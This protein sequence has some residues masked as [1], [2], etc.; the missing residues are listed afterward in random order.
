MAG[1]FTIV[2]LGE[3]L[4]DIFADQQIL[5][6]AP[7]NMAAAAHQLSKP[8]GG[9]ALVVSRVG[10]D[11]LGRQIIDQL[12][13]RQMEVGYVGTDPDRS[14]GKVFVTMDARGEPDFQIVENVA[15]DRIQFDS[16]DEALAAS[17]DGVCFG[18]LAQR[19]GESRSSI[20]HFAE[21]AKRAVRIFDV[22]LRQDYYDQR[23]IRQSC[24]L[25]NVVKLNIG[26]LKVIGR[27][28]DLGADLDADLDA[29]VDELEVDKAARTLVDRFNLDLVALTRGQLGTTLYTPKKKMEGRPVSYELAENADAVGAGDACSA[30][31]MVG[32]VCRWPLEK[33]LEVANRAGAFVASQLGATPQLP[34]SLLKLVQS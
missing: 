11:D 29:K 24:E 32:L 21:T 18:S 8:L 2:G 12:S 33:T 28:L 31:L 22:N 6:G 20:Q 15:W 7:L 34:D 17:C 9:C 30:G 14:T 26:E 5:G 13:K 27:L 23:L 25:A 19:C 4:F 10:R 3:A 1:S 16:H